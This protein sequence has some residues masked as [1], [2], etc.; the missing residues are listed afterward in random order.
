[1]S[2]LCLSPRAVSLSSADRILNSSQCHLLQMSSGI[3]PIQWPPTQLPNPP[4]AK[5]YALTA[6]GSASR[7]TVPHGDVTH[8]TTCLVPADG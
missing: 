8:L 7:A 1:M 6:L 3:L 5:P 2:G 4:H